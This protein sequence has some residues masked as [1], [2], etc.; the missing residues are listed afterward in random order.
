MTE[1]ALRR[2][3]PHVEAG[4]MT[5]VTAA[6]HEAELGG[7]RFD[8]VFGV[9]FPA[10]LRGQP[11]RE[12]EAIRRHLAPCGRLFVLFQSFHPPPRAA[13]DRATTFGPR[14]PR[15]HGQG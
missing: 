3:R 8:K 7:A 6:L 10:L 9:H 1:A 11:T 5:I 14:R 2:N 15:F 13:R 12:L 4:R